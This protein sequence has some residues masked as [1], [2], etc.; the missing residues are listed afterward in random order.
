MTFRARLKGFTLIELLVVIAI[1]AILIALLLPAVQQAREAARR[2]Q[3]RNHL[4]QLGL[5][6]HNYHDNYQYFPQGVTGVYQSRTTTGATGPGVGTEWRGHSVHWML[7]PYIDQ[8]PLYSQFNQNYGWDDLISSGGKSDNDVFNKV[9]ITPYLCPSDRL[10]AGTT[11]GQNNYVMSTGPTTGWTATAAE[12]VGIFSRRVS[13]GIRDI[14]DGT[15]NTIAAS[16]IIKG[17]NNNAVYELGPDLVRGIPFPSPYNRV[18]PTQAQLQAYSSACSAGTA[19]HHS[20][21]GLTWAGPMM[22]YTLFTT[23][24]PPN[25]PLHT[26]FTCAGCGAGDGEGMFPARSRHTGGAHHLLGDGAVRFISD[27]TD[28]S[29]YQNLG[30]IGGNETVGDF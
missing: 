18:K 23:V 27:N 24:A 12:S 26:C 16:E 25:P 22:N 20:W 30:T 2:T 4:K 1:I 19:N 13:R 14:T 11:Q 6:L 21:A 3:C 9:K 17:D 7:L 10:M 29:L 5:A 8:A 28:L 15:S